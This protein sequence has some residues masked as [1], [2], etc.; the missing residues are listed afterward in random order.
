M[1]K[2][3]SGKNNPSYG[4]HLSDEQKKKGDDLMDEHLFDSEKELEKS[5]KRNGYSWTIKS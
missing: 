4:K 1:S 5:S 3:M 2:R